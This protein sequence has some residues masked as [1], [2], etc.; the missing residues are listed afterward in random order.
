VTSG[1]DR[2]RDQRIDLLEVVAKKMDVGE[3]VRERR[4]RVLVARA[5]YRPIDGEG[6]GAIGPQIKRVVLRNV[7]RV[8]PLRGVGRQIDVL[9]IAVPARERQTC[10]EITAPRLTR[11]RRCL[12]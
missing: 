11:G 6:A 3:C 9:C 7:A 10:A 8:D 12:L 2:R 1:A 4:D 5:E